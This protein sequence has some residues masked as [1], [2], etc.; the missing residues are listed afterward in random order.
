MGEEPWPF[1][2]R[3]DSP[4]ALLKISFFDGDDLDSKFVEDALPVLRNFAYHTVQKLGHS[5]PGEASPPCQL[6][7]RH[8]LLKHDLLDD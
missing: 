8:I 4:S 3:R 2:Y 5:R 1:R 7:L 6:T